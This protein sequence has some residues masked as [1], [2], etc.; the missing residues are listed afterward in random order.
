MLSRRE[1]TAFSPCLPKRFK[2]HRPNSNCKKGILKLANHQQATDTDDHQ[3]DRHTMPQLQPIKSLLHHQNHELN[4][5]KSQAVREMLPRPLKRAMDL[6]QEKGA[7][8]WL[9]ALP[10]RHQ[11][12]SMNKC[13]FQDAL[14]IRY[15]WALKNIP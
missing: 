6:A 13:E 15:G 5:T 14:N 11:G 2:Y 4:E 7:S 8:I 12:F 9:T 3:S 1:R 10:L